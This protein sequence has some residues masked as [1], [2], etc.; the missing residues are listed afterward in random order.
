[1]NIAG[2]LL[3]L[4]DYTGEDEVVTSTEMKVMVD[5]EPHRDWFRS[6]IPTLDKE[7]EGFE[8]GELIAIS[9][10]RKSGK[11]L[12][13]QTLTKT[14]DE[15]GLASL[16]FSYELTPRQF[17]RAFDD[18]ELPV[19]L[20]PKKNRAHDL[21]WLQDRILESIAKFGVSVV[22]IDHLHFLFDLA[23]VRNSSIEIG[24]V[25]RFLKGLAIDLNITIFVLCHMKK[26]QLDTEPCD[27]DFRDSSF[28]ASESDT[29]LIIWRVKDSANQAWLK[30][31]YSRRT[32]AWEKKIPLI[33]MGGLLKEA[34]LNND[35]I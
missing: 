32:G 17:F 15:Q 3:K 9:G 10:P 35:H 28:V 7:I 26:L 23:K 8:A 20:M 19:F 27:V 6:G 12:F 24:Q 34:D 18:A 29:G 25:I 1:L 21:V 4:K 14:F 33:K 11:T 13:C 16:W 31:C 5:D 22:F 2:K 30:I